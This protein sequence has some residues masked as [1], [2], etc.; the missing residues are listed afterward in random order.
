VT[1][2]NPIDNSIYIV[3]QSRQLILDKLQPIGLFLQSTATI[4]LGADDQYIEEGA[5][6]SISFTAQTGST[7]NRWKIQSF[8]GSG[9][10]STTRVPL[11]SNSTGAQTTTTFFV[12]GSTTGSSTI[13]LTATASYN[14][15]GL[16]SPEEVVVKDSSIDYTKIRS[17]R[18]GA[19]VSSSFTQAELHNIGKW[20]TTIGGNVGIIYKGTQDPNG[21]SVTINWVDDKYLYIIYDSGYSDLSVILSG[22]LPSNAFG[23]PISSSTIVGPYKVYRTT[24][25]Q[26]GYAGNTITYTLQT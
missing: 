23:N 20:D 9:Y 19:S 12:T 7:A 16:A 26:A 1:A 14:S 21:H 17:V 6:G 10:Y 24:L 13:F 8:S 25:K 11:F 3:S 15:N 18:G 22:A 4:Q 5:T 2:S